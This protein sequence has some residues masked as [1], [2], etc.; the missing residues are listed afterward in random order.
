LPAALADRRQLETV[1]INLASNARDAIGD[2]GCIT[3]SAGLERVEEMAHPFGLE[4]GDYIRFDVSDDGVGMDELTAK[5]AIEPFFTTKEQGKGTGLGLS[6]ARGFAEQSGGAL[7]IESRL[8]CG[9][10][11]SLWL[12]ATSATETKP[13]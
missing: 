12:P 6:M 5:S 11:V 10:K 13:A 1:L 8:G 7:T 9:T 4:R 2:H 3:L